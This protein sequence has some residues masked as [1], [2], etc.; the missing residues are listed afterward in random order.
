MLIHERRDVAERYAK[1]K[2]PTA[3][4]TNQSPTASLVRGT[5]GF[6]RVRAV[7]GGL[8]NELYRSE[9]DGLRALAVVPVILFHA[10]FSG[11]SGGFVGVDVFFV[12]SGFLITS[13]ILAEREAGT[14]TIAGFY[15]RRARRI[16]PALTFVM[17]CTVPFALMWMPPAQLR[18]FAD[19]LVAVALF[20]SNFLFWSESGYFAAAAA[21]KPLLHTWSLAIEEQY[22]VVFPLLLM[23]LWFLGRRKLALAVVVMATVSF[24]FS[25]W[26]FPSD[27]AANFFLMPSRAWELLA[28]SILAFIEGGTPLKNRVGAWTAQ[29]LSGTG[30]LAIVASIF[31]F[32]E[33]TPFPGVAT[34]VPVGGTWLLLAFATQ[35]TFVGRIL[36]Q[37]WLVRVGLISYSA[38]LWHQPLFAFARLRSFNEPDSL[39]Y[40][41]LCVAVFALAYLSW[42]F[43]ELPFRQRRR[44]SRRKIFASGGAVAASFVAAGLLGSFTGIS[45]ARFTPAQLAV[46]DPS[47]SVDYDDCNWQRPVP[48][49]SKIK[50]CHFGAGRGEGP[51]VLLGDSHARALIAALD[52]NLKQRGI[53][54]MWVNNNYCGGLPGIYGARKTTA[55]KIKAC[56]ESHAVLLTH[57]RRIRPRAVVIALRWT[58]KLFPIEGK[59]EEL[60]F[61]NGEGGKEK[62]DADQKTVAQHPSGHL[63]TGADAKAEAVR[64]FLASYAVLGIPVIVQYPVPEVGWHVPNLNFK[65]LVFAGSFPEIISTSS[66][67]FAERNSFING[68]LDSLVNQTSTFAVKPSTLLCDTYMPSRCVAQFGSAPLYLD[69]DHLN[70][71]GAKLVVTEIMRH[72]PYQVL[73]VHP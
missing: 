10:G 21:E 46:I 51:V 42:R 38:Y 6:A 13:I 61:D 35:S 67:R 69:R 25:I 34:L 3:T 30:L 28:G 17:V 16:L 60:G 2:W 14:F 59:I 65:H 56:E 12:I 48:G 44:F 52:H 63:V 27:A 50:A 22:Y 43:V 55:R 36:S 5:R 1:S 4:L 18:E 73:A 47:E 20:C 68:V 49:F 57:W 41:A 40:G 37:R 33:A 15:E 45:A 70:T 32:D 54:A 66:A 31:A 72:V 58:T 7:S 39:V 8:L 23:I 29:I 19:S 26:G 24:A 62:K 9:I 64:R 11:F 71:A 53:P